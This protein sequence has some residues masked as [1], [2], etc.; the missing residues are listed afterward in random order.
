MSLHGVTTQKTNINSQKTTWD[1]TP[2]D[3][4]LNVHAMDTSD[5]T[6]LFL[7]TFLMKSLYLLVSYSRHYYVMCLE[8]LNISHLLCVPR[9]ASY[10]IHGHTFCGLSGTLIN[11]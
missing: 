6:R 5:A 8:T 2:E 7:V 1:N 9:G 11:L 3:H 4:S 10:G